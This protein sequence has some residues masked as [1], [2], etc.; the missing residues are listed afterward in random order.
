MIGSRLS[1]AYANKGIVGPD[2]TAI[3]GSTDVEDAIANGLGETTLTTRAVGAE[4]V[5]KFRVTK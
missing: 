3:F 5:V 4:S 1:Q 2:E